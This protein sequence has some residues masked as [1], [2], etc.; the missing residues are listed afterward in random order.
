[1]RCLLAIVL[2]LVL[3]AATA[4][5]GQP[6][7]WRAG[8]PRLRPQDSR[9]TTL[10]RQGVARSTTLRQLVERLEAGDLI[11]YI[12]MSPTLKKHL[13]GQ[14][15]WMTDTGAFRYVRI[16]IS[17]DLGADQLIAALAHE[18]QHA[19]EV[20]ADAG[21]VDEKTMAALYQRIGQPSRTMG[22]AWETAAAQQT[23]IRVRRELVAVPATAIAARL[24]AD[25]KM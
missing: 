21:V 8:G 20:A 9:T 4:A 1:M 16:A 5:A 14:M 25:D 12:A 19:V 7:W 10:L 6:D 17:T 15:T 3:T 24:R 23:G 11:V 22:A 18:L 2:S 13:A